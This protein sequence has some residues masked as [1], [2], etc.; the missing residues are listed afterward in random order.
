MR[1]EDDAEPRLG[2]DLQQLLLQPLD[3]PWQ[4]Q[5]VVMCDGGNRAWGIA[6]DVD[7]KTFGEL[8]INGDKSIPVAP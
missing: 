8:R 7:T 6:Y 3:V 4:E 5:V 2:P 1:D